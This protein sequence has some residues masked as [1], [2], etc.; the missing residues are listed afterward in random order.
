MPRLKKKWMSPAVPVADAPKSTTLLNTPA[1][2][3]VHQAAHHFGT[4]PAAFRQWAHKIGATAVRI[5][6]KYTYDLKELE[7]LWRELAAKAA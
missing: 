4:T 3:N 5:G 6:K 1:H 7:M 2:P